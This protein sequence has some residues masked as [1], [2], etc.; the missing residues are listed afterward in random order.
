[1]TNQTNVP[2]V[3]LEDSVRRL[4]EI[5]LALEENLDKLHDCLELLDSKPQLQTSLELYKHDV[6]TRARS[7][8]NEVKNL[9]AE[10]DSVKGVLGLNLKKQFKPDDES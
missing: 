7:L 6:Q 5:Q 10:L 4:R 2:K 8:E 1:M 9:R 3:K